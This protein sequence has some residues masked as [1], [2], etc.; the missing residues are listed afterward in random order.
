[1]SQQNNSEKYFSSLN[2]TLANEDTG[3]ELAILKRFPAKSAVSVCGSGG[4]SL[5]LLS[6]G[7]EE[8]HCVDLVTEQLYLA[9]LRRAALLGFERNEYFQFF[10]FPPE[11]VTSS[12]RRRELFAKLELSDEVRSFFQSYFESR[13]WESLLL[14][15]KWEK[16]FHKIS[17]LVRL[18]LGPH[19]QKLF[20]FDNLEEQREWIRSQFPWKRWEW[21]LRF[22]GNATFFNALLYK[23]SFVR[24]NIPENYFDFYKQ[25]YARLFDLG[26]ARENFFLQLSFL[27][28]LRYAEGN[29]VEA[30]EK[31]FQKCKSSLKEGALVRFERANLIDYLEQLPAKSI[32][33]VSL[34]DVPS[35][36]SGELEANY[37]TRIAPALR[38]KALVVLRSYLRVPEGTSLA[39]Y[40]EVTDDYANEI[41]GEKTQMY[42]VQ[43]FERTAD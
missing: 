40:R 24:K 20:D 32:D 35:Y 10:A 36:F 6:Q 7:L 17:K 25:A 22:V 4:R 30:H 27:G 12:R 1:M 33:F 11:Q 5:P 8:L 38:E 26:P 13:N 16:T 9:E 21:V 34:S 28:E 41:A 37:L 43:I 3:L 18:G 29:P 15:G 39:G 14:N 23:G 42:K 31:V 19:A 2:Y